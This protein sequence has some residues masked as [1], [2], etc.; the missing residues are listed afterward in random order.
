MLKA[1]CKKYYETRRAEFESG[2]LEYRELTEDD[3]NFVKDYSFQ[4]ASSFDTAVGKLKELKAAI[5][6]GEL[7]P[8]EWHA[9]DLFRFDRHL[10]NPLVHLKSK[11]VSVKPVA[12]NEGEQ[13]FVRD[14]KAFYESQ[15]E[16]FEGMELY[17]LRNLSKGKGIGFF[18]AGNFYS[19]FILW[20]LVG[21]RQ[22]V[23]FVDPKGIRNLQGEN[24]PKIEFHSTIKEIEDRLGGPEVTLNSFIISNTSFDEVAFWG[25]TKDELEERH[26]L[27]QSEDTT[28][29]IRAMLDRILSEK[30]VT[31]SAM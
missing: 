16:F 14:L 6:D 5:E 28:T 10:Y 4:V 2:F 15:P 7:R 30:A 9:L 17:L 27:F 31:E 20:L 18:E 29:Y 3:P 25:Y 1:Y 23:T 19:D 12:L 13:R 11:D 22:C 24:D 21:D 26:V 8:L